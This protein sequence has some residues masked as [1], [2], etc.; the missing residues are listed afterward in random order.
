MYLLYYI[1]E[2]YSYLEFAVKQFAFIPVAASYLM[3]TVLIASL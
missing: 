1:I 2:V 3:F